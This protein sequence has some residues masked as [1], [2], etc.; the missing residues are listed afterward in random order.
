MC[1]ADLLYS[2]QHSRLSPE[3]NEPHGAPTECFADE[4]KDYVSSTCTSTTTYATAAASTTSV[5]TTAVLNTAAAVVVGKFN[6]PTTH[7]IV[8]WIMGSFGWT[9]GYIWQL[10]NCCCFSSMGWSD[11]VRWQHNSIGF[12]GSSVKQY[13]TGVNQSQFVS[14]ELA[15]INK[16]DTPTLAN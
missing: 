7:Y 15:L 1:H 10:G 2:T 8:S 11:G 4:T 3:R 5:P 9:K 13:S 16:T 12:L 14:V 6:T